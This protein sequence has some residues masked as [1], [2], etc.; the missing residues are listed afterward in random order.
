MSIQENEILD[1]LSEHNF[2]M[3]DYQIQNYV[4]KSQVTNYRQIKQSLIELNARRDAILQ[5][6]VDQKRRKIEKK[7]IK[8]DLENSKDQF[9]K[10]LLEIDLEEVEKDLEYAEKRFLIQKKEYQLFLDLI[11]SQFETKEQLEEYITNPEEERKY[12]IAR[13]GKQAAIDL[14]STGRIGTGNMDSISMMS[15]VDQVQTLKVA[16][17]YSGLMGVGIAKLQQEMVPY[18]QQLEKTSDKILPTFEGIE[19]NLNIDL[20]QKLSYARENVQSSNQSEDL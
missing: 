17:Q 5:I 13:M 4:I 6:E 9:K 12:W 3:S 1:V 8:Y 20:L 16:I 10:E 7:K 15:E 2:G 18:L 11:T 19:E 14:L